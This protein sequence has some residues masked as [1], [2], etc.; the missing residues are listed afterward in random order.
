[1][2]S[3]SL[4]SPHLP[5]NYAKL[6]QNTKE[7]NWTSVLNKADK[8]HDEKGERL[9]KVL[10]AIVC[11][12]DNFQNNSKLKKFTDKAVTYLE[13]KKP[14]ITK[15]AKRRLNEVNEK[16]KSG[17]KGKSLREPSTEICPIV[18]PP[19]QETPLKPSKL[20]ILPRQLQL[21]IADFVVERG[22]EKLLT[23]E[24]NLSYFYTCKALGD[25]FYP[26][27]ETKGKG[28]AVS[29]ILR[30][31][32]KEN[33]RFSQMPAK[34]F[35]EHGQGVKNLDLSGIAPRS[36]TFYERIVTSFPNVEMLTLPELHFLQPIFQLSKLKTLSISATTFLASDEPYF[37]NF[38]ALETL[39][40]IRCTITSEI[41]REIG[42]FSDLTSLSL[43]ETGGFLAQDVRHLSSLT[44]LQSL[45]VSD[46]AVRIGRITLTALQEIAKIGTLTHLDISR[47]PNINNTSLLHLAPLKNLLSLDHHDPTFLTGIGLQNLAQAVPALNHLGI[48]RCIHL[49]N[50][51]LRNLQAFKKLT[52]LDIEH[53]G[54]NDE[55]L[56]HIVRVVSLIKLNLSGSQGYWDAGFA[57]LG[58][59]KNLRT[60]QITER[61]NLF[62]FLVPGAETVFPSSQAIAALKEKNKELEV[63][64]R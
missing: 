9:S 2:T 26:F 36:S 59:L 24:N 58:E 38:R 11:K 43:K 22:Q 34:R 16:L 50:A 44:K 30:K 48:N 64:V 3:F 53:A 40:L 32:F 63:I 21:L 51:D 45:D 12:T 37:A 47:C 1:M 8:K 55:G 7:S 14:K 31:V 56:G 19:L 17:S 23:K 54:V 28:D 20:S 5:N 6:L 61:D 35:Q 4:V 52:S 15:N 29:D 41:L 42:M 13:T 27:V 60:L 10:K 49:Q 33:Q 18:P 25:C 57:Q 39:K 46:H 62:N